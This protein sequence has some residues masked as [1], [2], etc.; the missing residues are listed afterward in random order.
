LLLECSAE[1]AGATAGED[2]AFSDYGAGAFHHAYHAH[3]D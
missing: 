1:I 3:A 2:F